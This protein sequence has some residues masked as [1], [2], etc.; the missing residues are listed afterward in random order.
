MKK[1]F[2]GCLALT[3][4]TASLVGIKIAQAQRNSLIVKDANGKEVIVYQESHALVIWAG[5]YKNWGKLNNLQYEAK[6]VVTALQKQGFQVREIPNPNRTKLSNGIKDFIDDYG[7]R[8]NNRL[9]I[10]F[11]GHGYT[12]QQTKGY[13]VPVDAPD[14]IVDEQGFLKAALS[15]EQINSWATQMEAKHVLFVFDSCFSGT[16][17]KQRSNGEDAGNAYIRDVMNK[18]V[19]QFLT[20]GDANEKV[21]A[22]SVF[23]PL[24]LRAL[25]GEADYTKDGYVTGSELGLYLTQ[26][27]PNLTRGNQHPQF[28]TILDVNLNRGDI[29][30]RSSIAVV[31]P[32]PSPSPPVLTPPKPTPPTQPRSTLI[33][34]TTGVDYTTLRELLQQKKWKEA[35]DITFKLMLESSKHQNQDWTNRDWLSEKAI[36]SFACEDLKII[37]RLWSEYSNNQLGLSAQLKFWND[38]KNN[39]TT[40]I[41][42]Y[43]QFAQWVQWI[44]PSS[45]SSGSSYISSDDIKYAN[46]PQGHLPVQITYPLG[47]GWSDGGSNTNRHLLYSRFADCRKKGN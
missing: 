24:F 16:I 44:L 5:D 6:E 3:G 19:R 25:E 47:E 10:F 33:S 36:N 30:F 20:A 43:R 13:L 18:P 21:P 28:G 14:P 4:I 1:A 12:R 27:L 37:D 9:V 15:M 42:A 46:P 41:E 23:T 32:Q 31:S 17:F 29:V 39:S 40:I 22:K 7:Y 34:S 35:D 38:A 8:Q 2:W 45:I 26:H 11:A